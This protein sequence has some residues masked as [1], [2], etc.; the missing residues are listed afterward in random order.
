MASIFDMFKPAA[1]ATP[2]APA[3]AATNTT[4]PNTNTTPAP[5]AT[6]ANTAPVSPLDNF[7][8]LWQPV[9]GAK[10]EEPFQFNSDPTKL[11]DAAKTVDFRKMVTP[12]LQA[13]INAGGT[14]AQTA[15]MEAMNNMN[16]MAFAQS[17]HAASKI[18]EAALQAQE[19]RFKEMLPA[20]IKQHTVVDNLKQ[21]NPLMAD[22]A[23][24]P[25]I[26]ALQQ[27]FTVKYPHATAQQINDHVNEFLNGAADRIT[28]LRPVKADPTKRQEMDWSKFVE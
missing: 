28:G 19:Q 10:P 13:K 1:P 11:M 25:M 24:A 21:T 9:Q 3:S 23:M 8:D 4:V 15:L 14:E 5:A 2:A 26:G 7:K 12:E 20:L 16:Q 6:P 18:T 22:P 17:S 27:Q